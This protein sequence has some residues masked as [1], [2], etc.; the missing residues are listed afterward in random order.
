MLV[1]VDQYGLVG[2]L[3]APPLATVIQLF[4]RQFLRSTRLPLTPQLAQ[5]ISALQTRLESAQTLLAAHSELSA[6]EITSLIER[7]TKLIAR[8]TP[9]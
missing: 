6:P 3:I 5:P 7:L 1:L 2:I 9:G 4:A 8:A